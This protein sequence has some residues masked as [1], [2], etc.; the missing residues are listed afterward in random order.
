MMQLTALPG[1]VSVDEQPETTLRRLMIIGCTVI[2]VAFGGV[3]AWLFLAPLDSA[4]VAQGSVV[5]DSHRKTVQHLEG[6]IVRS[7]MV[8]EGDTVAAGQTL[9][10]L[11]G[12]QAQ[13][14][15]GQVRNQYWTAK[16]RVAR[17]EAEQAGLDRLAW[18]AEFAEADPKLL[19]AQQDMFRARHD[20]FVAQMAVREK[21]IGQIEQQIV[22]LAAQR[23]ATEESL[24]YNATELAAVEKLYKQG[25]ERRPRLLQLQ[26]MSAEMQGSLGELSAKIARAEQEKAEAE[27]ELMGQRNTRAQEIAVELQEART[28]LLDLSDRLRAAQDVMNRTDVKAPQDGRVVD[29]KVYTVGGVVTPGQPLMDIVPVD[30]PMLVEARVKPADIDVVHVG[31]SANIHL[32][33]YKQRTTPPVAGTVQHVS[34]DRLVDPRTGEP[35]FVALVRPLPE[36]LAKIADVQLSPGM[37]AEV[38]ITTGE[39]RAIDYLLSP[40]TDS[41]RRGF[42]EQ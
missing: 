21:R 33:A 38:F 41:M 3:G 20:T 10:V 8:K 27:L 35:Y 12:A 7:V 9:M 17:L 2:G 39:R 14:A 6:G 37:P 29:L 11:E 42:R 16:A 15:L 23:T 4:A 13:S 22:A 36:E 26:R 30:D 32:T 24:G 18:P 5:V 40:L 31:M 25:Y 1:T 28:T 19:D 34:A